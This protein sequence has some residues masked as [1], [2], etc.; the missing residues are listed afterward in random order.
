MVDMHLLPNPPSIKGIRMGGPDSYPS[1]AF[2]GVLSACHSEGTEA[3]RPPWLPPVC[4]ESWSLFQPRRTNIL[5]QVY[6]HV[7]SKHTPRVT[8][9][10]GLTRTLHRLQTIARNASGPSVL[11]IML[12]RD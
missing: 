1:V 12:K 2:S 3:G 9:P 4:G 6:D 5:K 10:T 11:V 7:A 8:Y